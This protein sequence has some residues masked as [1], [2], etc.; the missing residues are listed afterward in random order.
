LL[1]R[2]TDALPTGERSSQNKGQQRGEKRKISWRDRGGK[3]ESDKQKQK[4]G[5]TGK[6]KRRA[7]FHGSVTTNNTGKGWDSDHVLPWNMIN[8]GSIKG[9]ICP[10]RA[11]RANASPKKNWNN[12]K[13]EPHGVTEITGKGKKPSRTRCTNARRKRARGGGP[14]QKSGE[15]NA[16][17]D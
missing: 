15:L 16:G 5:S 11:H 6:S 2:Q 3:N 10:K 17:W 8:R 7:P 4:E 14:K 9:E 13:T 1:K 12:L